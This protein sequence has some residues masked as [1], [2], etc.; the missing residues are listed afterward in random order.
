[1]FLA[2]GSRGRPG[3]LRLLSGLKTSGSLLVGQGR[4]W[5]AVK[6][7]SGDG[8]LAATGAL[9]VTKTNGVA[10]APS[11]TTDTTNAA[12]ISSGILPATRLAQIHRGFDTPINL[13]LTAAVAANALTIAVKDASTGNDPSAANPVILQVRSPAGA[14]SNTSPGTNG[15]PVFVSITSALSVT[16]PSGQTLGTANN[17]PFRFWIVGMNNSGT[18]ELAVINCVVGAASPT[19]IAAIP[20]HNLINTTAIA[21][22]P[23][24]GIYYSATARS[25]LSFS[26]LGFVEFDAGQATAGTYATS[27]TSL[28][29]FGADIK[30][31]GDKLQVS[32]AAKIDTFST[33]STTLTDITG[34][35]AA[36]TPTSTTSLV[37]VSVTL[38]HC[39]DTGGSA[40]V[41]ALLR[42]GSNV[43]G[44]TAASTRPSGIA[45]VVRTTD[46]LSLQTTSFVY[47]D[48]PGSVSAQTYKLQALVQT[49]GTYFVNRTATDTD[50]AFVVRASSHIVLEEV[51]V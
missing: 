10:F 32:Q 21:A 19:Q 12:N 42:N 7:V 2:P 45:S 9:T 37:K 49:A 3:L 40:A 26:I 8:T 36:V 17:V 30:K 38:N 23:S 51:M 43:L 25:N 31:P 48:A 50:S 44:G 34:M 6:A 5:P 22:A 14:T 11:A 29:L 27:P 28:Q 41:V 4:G 15:A 24:A 46:G 1:M 35:T 16:V 18:I 13:Q 20:N 47:Y 39:T 33:A